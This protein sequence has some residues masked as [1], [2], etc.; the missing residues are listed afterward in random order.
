MRG[1]ETVALKNVSFYYLDESELSDETS[2]DSEVSAGRYESTE[3]CV[4][5]ICLNIPAGSCTVLCGRS[6]SGKSTVLRL[7]DGLAGTFFPGEKSGVVLVHGTDVFD[8]SPR[9]RTKSIGVVTQ[10]P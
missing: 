10:D 6:G 7:I 1:T 4:Q 5:D 8:L 3:S 2:A 9:N